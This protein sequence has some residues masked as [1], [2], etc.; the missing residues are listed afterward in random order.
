V[1]AAVSADLDLVSRIAERLAVSL[2][3][4]ADRTVRE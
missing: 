4:D 1:R 2:P 3:F